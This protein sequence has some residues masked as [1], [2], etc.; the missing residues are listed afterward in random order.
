MNLH[1]SFAALAFLMAATAVLAVQVA[2]A[3]VGTPNVPARIEAHPGPAAHPRDTSITFRGDYE[4]GDR[5]QWLQCFTQGA[6]TCG[7]VSNPVRQGRY[8]GLFSTEKDRRVGPTERAENLAYPGDTLGTES[9]YAWS[10]LFPRGFDTPSWANLHQ[11][12]PRY[13]DVTGCVQEHFYASHQGRG[14]APADALFLEVCAGDVSSGRAPRSRVFK[15]QRG[16][17]RGRWNDYVLHVVWSYRSDGLLVVWHRVQGRAWR[18]A[19]LYRGP[20]MQYERG[21]KLSIGVSEGFYRPATGRPTRVYQD[22]FVRGDSFAAVARAAF[23]S[24]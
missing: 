13:Y 5:S 23:G 7:A 18:R 19:L 12:F 20:T 10:T 14:P 11:F 24:G 21:A 15:L 16:L 8:A 4:S 17:N 2:R 1:R 3:L 6:A 9:Y 22:G